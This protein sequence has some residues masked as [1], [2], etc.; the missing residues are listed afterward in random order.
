MAKKCTSKRTTAK[1]DAGFSNPKHK[2][3]KSVR[4]RQKQIKRGKK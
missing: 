3:P 2:L 1:R 4:K